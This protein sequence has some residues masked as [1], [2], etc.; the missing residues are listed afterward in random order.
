MII[1]SPEIM[2]ARARGIKF[3]SK[4]DSLVMRFVG[5]VLGFLDKGFFMRLLWSRVGKTIYYPMSVTHPFLEEYSDLAETMIQAEC[6]DI[7]LWLWAVLYLFPLPAYCSWFRWRME[8]RFYLDGLRKYRNSRV[9]LPSAIQAA[10]DAL[11]ECHARPWP[12]RWM[13][14]W[15]E[16]SL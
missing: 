13:Q 1:D 6:K 7:P 9:H 5:W 16:R 12:R 10:V 15:L 3:V 2:K 11:W 8:R 14:R 4:E